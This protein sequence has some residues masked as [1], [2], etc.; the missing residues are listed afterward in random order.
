LSI[1]FSFFARVD[2][3]GRKSYNVPMSLLI[4]NVRVLGASKE[5]PE[6]SDVYVAGEI[7][8]A[9]GS[10]PNKSAD[11]IIDGQGAYLAPG[12]V[13]IDTTSDHYLTLFSDPAQEGFLKQGVTTIAGG[14]CGAS[15][16]PLLYG[17]LEAIRKWGDPST[18]NIDWHTVAE[19][20][21]VLRRRPLGVNFG[22]F[23]GHSTVRRAIIG[24][25]VRD[26]TKNEL[27]V[28]SGIIGQGMNEGAL[29]V[30]VGL[31]YVHTRGTSY[32]ELKMIAEEVKKREGVLAMHLRRTGKEI[33]KGVAEAIKIQ[34][35][36]GASVLLNHFMPVLGAEEDYEKAI[37][38]IDEL[39][40]KTNFHFAVHPF[41]DTLLTLYRLLPEWAQNGNIDLMRKNIADE[42]LSKRILK[43][44]PVIDPETFV[45]ESSPKKSMDGQTLAKFMELYGLSDPQQAIL[46]LMRVTALK[47][48][49]S[50]PNTNQVLLKKVLSHPRAI[51][52]SHA[53]S[54]QGNRASV[55]IAT[56]LKQAEEAG[57]TM[58]DV[59][60]KIAGLPAKKLSLKGRGEIREGY[61]ADLVLIKNGLVKDVVIAGKIT[62]QEGASIPATYGKP[63]LRNQ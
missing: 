52:S 41:S 8:S 50:F 40:P 53:A 54:G 1:L 2:I 10:F 19:L 9:I 62:M 42:W 51:V 11:E 33:D 44:L 63:I 31:E 35:E 47:A 37:A 16:A 34:K 56:F 3:K 6:R 60:S 43:D 29:G 7:I 15:L 14:Q 26:L 22:T 39:G 21:E 13:D 4:R 25:E 5:L 49:V 58:E 18:I 55:A 12:F 45:I 24:E 32:P 27:K 61:I 17:S 57:M 48:S 46:Q 23:V 20:M 38:L 30:S 28:M 59:V 36:T